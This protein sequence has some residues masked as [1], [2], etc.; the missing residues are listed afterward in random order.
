MTPLLLALL[1]LSR[2]DSAFAAVTEVVERGIRAGVY[3][4][5]VV[6]VG[7]RDTVLFARGFGHATWSASAF[8]PSPSET[9]W[10]LASLTKVV[11]TAS[12][13]LVLVDQGHVSL[14]APVARY[15]RRFAGRGRERI[16][17]RMLL[18][19]TSGLPAYVA[20]HRMAKTRQAAEDLLY[21]TAPIRVPGRV[22]AYSDVNAML[23]GLLVEAVA[24]A[25]LDRFTSK[26]VFAPLGMMA[27]PEPRAQ[28]PEF[29]LC[30][31]RAAD[32][33]LRSGA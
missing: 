18:D 4:G 25:P 8:R 7:R 27:Q 14:D 15:L 1:Q 22:T 10:D 3:P 17:V 33:A 11:A 26:E 19:H 21:R 32:R 6:V 13:V 23:L 2:S 9:R 28:G 20:L 5:A 16:T 24:G 31:T 29:T 12:A 30:N